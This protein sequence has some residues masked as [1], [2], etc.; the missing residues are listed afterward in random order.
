MPHKGCLM[1]IRFQLLW[2]CTLSGSQIVVLMHQCDIRANI[3]TELAIFEKWWWWWCSSSTLRKIAMY[4]CLA[5]T[6]IWH[7]DT[8]GLQKCTCQELGTNI[9]TSNFKRLAKQWHKLF[10][11]R[12]LKN[13][14]SKE[15]RNEASACVEKKWN[16]SHTQLYFDKVIVLEE[17]HGP[18]SPPSVIST[19]LLRTWQ[20]QIY[21]LKIINNSNQDVINL[22]SLPM[23][24][25]TL[26]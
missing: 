15:E 10:R 11:R 16:V 18:C 25:D 7:V 20:A 21:K 6:S 22:E 23:N 5:A 13:A 14:H 1:Q 24:L 19:E 9:P 17:Q 3:N 2:A 8:V 12:F 26:S 4:S